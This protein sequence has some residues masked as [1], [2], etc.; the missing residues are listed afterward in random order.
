MLGVFELVTFGPFTVT[1]CGLNIAAGLGHM[2]GAVT[3]G[4]GLATAAVPVGDGLVAAAEPPVAPV[5]AA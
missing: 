4:A 3:V 1:P 5:R 2:A